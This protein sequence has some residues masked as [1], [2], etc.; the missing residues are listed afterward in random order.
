EGKH[1][2]VVIVVTNGHDLFAGDAAVIGPSLEGVAL[3]ASLVQDI[4]DGEIAH[5]IFGSQHGDVFFQPTCCQN[6][7]GLMHA[8]DASAEHGLNRIGSE[9]ALQRDAEVDIFQIFFE[10]A[11][12]ALV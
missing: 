10:P 11:L 12:N 6:P 8:L 1:F 2:N 5:R 4:D 3:G 7:Q 9:R